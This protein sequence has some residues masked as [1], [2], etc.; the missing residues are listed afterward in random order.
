ML[1]LKNDI[2]NNSLVFEQGGMIYKTIL[3][4]ND[5]TNG[6]EYKF[7]NVW[8]KNTN[9]EIDNI[10]PIYYGNGTEWIKFKN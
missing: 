7:T 8:L 2:P 1:T 5:F 9:G 4:D 6:L 10:T 3:F